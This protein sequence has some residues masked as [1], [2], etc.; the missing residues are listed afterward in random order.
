[1]HVPVRIRMRAGGHTHRRPTVPKREPPCPRYRRQ[2][3]EDGP[4]V[5]DHPSVA[6]LMMQPVSSI[7][8]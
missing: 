8:T 1:M 2:R 5:T 6:L 3:M 7:R 4:V